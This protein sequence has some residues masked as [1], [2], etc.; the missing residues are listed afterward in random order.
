MKFRSLKTRVLIWFGSIVS[1]LLVF[2]SIG[3]Y[4]FFNQSVNVSIQTQLYKEA[5]FIEE[6]IEVNTNINEI[7]V[8]PSLAHLNIAI[9]QVSPRCTIAKAIS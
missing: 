3:F 2:F 9:C 8:N 7:L 4:Y 6:E 1:L 5:L